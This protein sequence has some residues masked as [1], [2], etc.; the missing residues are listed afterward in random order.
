MRQLAV[1]GIALFLS[2]SAG[3]APKITLATIRYG[4]SPRIRHNVWANLE[5]QVQNP[6]QKPA[7]VR[8][9]LLPKAQ[10]NLTIY[11]HRLRLA[12]RTSL[13][14]RTLITVGTVENYTLEIHH[15]GTIVGK[16][17][18]ITRLTSPLSRTVVFVNDNRNITVGNIATNE[19]LHAKYFCTFLKARQTPYHWAGYDSVHMIVMMQ[20]DFDT[21]SSRQV[22]AIL[23][24]V[25]RGGTLVFADPFGLVAAGNTPLRKLLPVTPLQIRKVET[26]TAL[27]EIGTATLQWPEGA[28]FLESVP[29]GDG[30]TPLWHSDFPLIRWKKYNLGT[31]GAW[32]INLGQAGL[33]HSNEGRDYAAVWNYTLAM[34][35]RLTYASSQ[36]D[37]RLTKAVDQL[38]GMKIPRPALVGSILGVFLV[39]VV[40]FVGYGAATRQQVQSW[41]VLAAMSALVTG[42]IFWYAAVRSAGIGNLTAAMI[43]FSVGGVT[44]GS[45]E[46][47]IGL[48][49]KSERRVEIGG[50]GVD[51][52]MRAF[53]PTASRVVKR[54][55]FVPSPKPFKAAS[56]PRQKFVDLGKDEIIRDP[57]R[58]RQVDGSDRLEGV[59][60]RA[61]ATRFHANLYCTVEEPYPSLPRLE[62]RQGGPMIASWRLPPDIQARKG[63]LICGAGF[64]PL[65]FSGKT[66]S[67]TP[68]EDGEAIRAPSPEIAALRVFLTG[69]KQPA[70]FLAIFADALRDRSGDLPTDFSVQGRNVFF[71][72][73]RQAL[74]PGSLWLPRQAIGVGADLPYQR[75]LRRDAG[76]AGMTER[77]DNRYHLKAMLPPGLS[78]LAV[79]TVQVYFEAENRGGNLDFSILLGQLGEKTREASIEPSRVEKGLY[80]FENVPHAKVIDKKLGSFSF[81]VDVQVRQKTADVLQMQKENTWMVRDLGVAVG[82]ELAPAKAGVF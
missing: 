2:V 57:L 11:E 52:H 61:M 59:M 34:G 32:A 27:E 26:I 79:D 4:T 40:A 67:L 68:G 14:F 54:Q 78:L 51:R 77:K 37:R 23:A 65:D 21:M 35:G 74:A 9:V 73:V 1:A 15:R 64:F 31:V 41:L 28:D 7:D 8:L 6:D 55:L 72:P 49:S 43:D 36:R 38:T 53:V 56:G 66:C 5:Y 76:S 44:E 13:R 42:G 18:I 60:L 12:P 48:L 10:R 16:M 81:I 3:A 58:V 62:W 30:L 50:K 46:Q 29:R 33:R 63:A 17:P 47:I 45:G 71:V 20:P 19:Q 25:A 69:T 80:V 39:L 70:P 82:G 22:D 24:Y 75:L